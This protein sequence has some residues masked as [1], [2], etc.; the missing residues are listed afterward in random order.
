MAIGFNYTLGVNEQA[1][2]D[3]LETFLK[4]INDTKF[5]VGVDFIADTTMLFSELQTK[6]DGLENSFK[7]SLNNFD[8]NANGLEKEVKR[9]ASKVKL[10]VEVDVSYFDLAEKMNEA[11]VPTQNLTKDIEILQNRLKLTLNDLQNLAIEN[12]VAGTVPTDE[13]L[14]SITALGT[15]GT[16]MKEINKTA[17]A[18][19]VEIAGWQQVI[20]SQNKLFAETTTQANSVAQAV[21][22][23]SQNARDEKLEK[24]ISVLQR[25]LDLEK[26]NILL[27]KEY[28]AATFTQQQAIEAQLNAIVLTGDKTKQVNENFSDLNLQL[29][30]LKQNMKADYISKYGTAMS[31][32]EKSIAGVAFQFVSID[33]A[34]DA[35]QSAMREATSYAF[36]LDEAYTNIR[37]TMDVTSEE[38]AGWVTHAKDVADANGVVQGSVID[39]MKVYAT[40]GA[41]ISDINDQLAGTIAFQNVTGWDADTTTKSVQTMLQQFKLIEDAGMSSAEAINKAG[42]IVTSVGYSL[43]KEEADAIREIVSAVETAGAVVYEAGGSLEWYSA[44]AGGLAETMNA[45]GSE[46]G[47]AMKMITARVL[48]QKQVLEDMGESTEDFELKTANAEKALKDIGV[49]IRGEGGD[50]RDIEDIIKDVA[51]RWDGLTESTKQY[52]AEMM[53][54]NNRR[55]YLQNILDNYDRIADLQK[56]AETSEGT[57]MEASQKKAESLEGALNRVK[58]TLGELY[59]VLL[60]SGTI[61]DTLGT[62]DNLLKG[63]V[64][65]LEFMDGKW[66]VTFAAATGA[67]IT[68]KAAMMGASVGQYLKFL[69]MLALEHIGLTGAINATA[70]ATTALKV[71]MGGFVV[72]AVVAG[73]SALVSHFNQVQEKME[74]ISEAAKQLQTD[75]EDLDTTDDLIK[76]F[77][78]V[79]EQLESGVKT[80]AE[81]NE[82]NEKLVGLRQDLI[83]KSTTLQG[84]LEDNTK[85]YEEQ[86]DAME[87]ATAFQRED[88]IRQAIKD[89]DISDAQKK[90]LS[91]YID[92]QVNW[93]EGLTTKL[94]GLYASRDEWTEKFNFA[95]TDEE[96]I[97]A[98]TELQRL[99]KLI[100]QDEE[101][102]YQFQKQF[103]SNMEKALGINDAINAAKEAGIPI[104]ELE[105]EYSEQ[106]KANYEELLGTL[107][108]I[109]D[110]KGKTGETPEEDPQDDTK[111]PEQIAEENAK[112]VQER[113]A[114]LVEQLALIKELRELAQDIGESGYGVEQMQKLLDLYPEFTGDIT[115]AT[116]AQEFL[117]NKIEEMSTDAEN[118]YADVA[119]I[120]NQLWETKIRNSDTWLEH[121]QDVTETASAIALQGLGNDLSEFEAFMNAKG[122]LYQFD[123]ENAA[124][125]A[126]AEQMITGQMISQMLDY[127][128]QYLDQ[129]GIGRENDY[130]GVI[131]F[132]SSQEAAEYKTIDELT[133]AWQQFYQNKLAAMQA[134]YNQLAAMDD[135][136]ARESGQREESQVATQKKKELEAMKA[137]AEVA[138]NAWNNLGSSFKNTMN[139]FKSNKLDVGEITKP[140]SSSS[141]KKDSSTEKE[142]EDMEDLRDVYY[143][144]DVALKHIENSLRMNATLQKKA[145]GKQLQNLLKEEIRLLREK[146]EALSNQKDAMVNQANILRQELSNVGFHF[147]DNGDISNYQAQLKALTDQANS[148]SGDS[149]T[150]AIN[151]VKDIASKVT[152]YTKLMT[153]SIANVSEEWEDMANQIKEAQKELAETVTDTQKDMASALENY[154]TKRYNTAK[155]ALEKEKKL[156]ESQWDEEDHAD[157]LASEQRKLDEIRQQMTDLS[158]DQSDYGKAKLEA[159]RKEYEEQQAV[160]DEINKQWERE[161]AANRFEEEADKLDQELED[162]LSPE[163]LIDMVNQAITSGMITLGDEVIK[164]DG[165]M[166]DWLNETGDGLYAIGDI[167]REELIGNLELAAGLMADMGITSTRGVGRSMPSLASAQDA[168][169]IN[170]TNVLLATTQETQAMLSRILNSDGALGATYEIDASMTIEG[171]VTEDILP[172]V[173]TMMAR[174][175]TEIINVITKKMSTK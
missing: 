111:T 26:Q 153:D 73:I 52:T 134:E 118:A 159:L 97:E 91:N 166:T 161:Q 162:I 67:L 126:E 80:E 94:E 167:L 131:E 27:S 49:S 109:N 127:Y 28:A 8:I 139:T 57:L 46:V 172:Q 106:A 70:V 103:I 120:D 142:V 55:S 170:D 47:N 10:P 3:N 168:M 25:K 144:V 71:A 81:H 6:L 56:T 45:T 124:N 36:D 83:D 39:M 150:A 60:D 136:Y 74:N 146:A 137:A 116:Q 165:I 53:A 22:K 35:I 130:T 4:S 34:V 51:D 86:A 14:Q 50:L 31:Q 145:S 135:M 84:I 119:A 112:A 114:A 113:N 37:M 157:E 141:S 82:L 158:R 129:K 163:N 152:E 32:L 125:A 5:K 48:Q 156:L 174:Q 133:V 42:D 40:A 104:D 96:R 24:Q 11:S 54:G 128:G 175:K 101:T 151:N 75:L 1:S 17:S 66:L 58:N 154:W 21:S 2:L 76:Q 9:K 44:I 15:M 19:R 63:L 38:F 107:Q 65:V 155:E 61:N 79:N 108:E 92:N 64:E 95:E 169:V 171:N 132:L 105:V 173:Q 23:I 110:E 13:I 143:E 138:A 7:F 33:R 18:I 59:G 147:E 102:Q 16:D 117:N 85:S 93:I 78:E 88:V 149:K 87:R 140:T 30:E 115:D 99:S 160:I 29:R 20:K 12:D 121:V 89:T 43:Q 77:R 164:V 123:Y 72:G 62:V 122:L 90:K 98:Q 41:E 69:G 100:A 68:F 148:L